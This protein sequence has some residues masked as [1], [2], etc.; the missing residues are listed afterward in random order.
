MTPIGEVDG[1]TEIVTESS[2][3]EVLRTVVDPCSAA[4]GSDL[5]VVEM[6]LVDAID[7]SGGEVSVYLLMTTPACEM[8]PYFHE[9]I[10]AAVGALAGIN[11]VDVN[12]DHGFEWTSDMMSDT[13]QRRREAVREEYVGQQ[14]NRQD[15]E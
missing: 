3:K 12:T 15:A 13:A 1:D 10:E 8:V 9:E 6:G 2:V 4:N 11:S 5:N 14:R 7:V